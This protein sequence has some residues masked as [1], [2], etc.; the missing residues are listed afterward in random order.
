MTDIILAN[1]LSACCTAIFCFMV[2]LFF[3]QRAVDKLRAKHREERET[4]RE[5]RLR[6]LTPK[7][8][9]SYA[10]T[11]LD[12]FEY[13]RLKGTVKGIRHFAYWVG[14]V[15]LTLA[16]HSDL[17][18]SAGTKT[19]TIKTTICAL[20][21]KPNRFEG[22]RVEVFGYFEDDG[23]RPK[24]IT[25]PSCPDV[26]IE[27]AL[28]AEGKED[29]LTALAKGRR[30]TLD[31]TITAT[32]VGTFK[33]TPTENGR[34][35][36]WFCGLKG[37]I[38]VPKQQSDPVHGSSLAGQSG[39]EMLQDSP[40]QQTTVCELK[41]DPERF[42]GRRIRASGYILNDGVHGSLLVDPSCKIAGVLLVSA[43]NLKGGDKL[44][45]AVMSGRPGTIDKTIMVTLVGVY[46]SETDRKPLP[47]LSVEEVQ[48]LKV[49]PKAADDTF[50]IH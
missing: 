49:G 19:M 37:L 2:C 24:G 41:S 45:S 29:L 20:A 40:A 32:F 9:T 39:V 34:M 21:E 3:H 18:Q 30:G 10:P 15:V 36:L 5:G 42:D 33:W 13:A 7:Q 35:E 43:S 26:R 4:N 12:E 8:L 31:K 17:G 28:G 50:Q 44:V 38:V 16:P 25:D 14:A 23:V 1:A 27:V 46:R 22:K 48:D 11:H 47:E 6:E